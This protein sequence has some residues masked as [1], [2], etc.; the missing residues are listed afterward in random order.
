MR[1][2]Y[3]WTLTLIATFATVGGCGRKPVPGQ[4]PQ[5]PGEGPSTGSTSQ[6]TPRVV[7]PQPVIPEEKLV[8]KVNG[9][10][11]TQEEFDKVYQHVLADQDSPPTTD[12]KFK[13]RV[14]ILNDLIMARIITQK[15]LEAD[16]PVAATEI[17]L[18][19]DRVRENFHFNEREFLASLAAQGMTLEQFR[20]S[21]EKEIKTNKFTEMIMNRYAV[22]PTED[23]LRDWYEEHRAAYRIPE[24]VR[25]SHILVAL[26]R[27]ATEGQI[28]QAHQ[29][30]QQIRTEI[31]N[32][33]LDFGAAAEKYSD[34]IDSAT[35]GG[36]LG[37]MF[38]GM[39]VRSFEEAAFALRVGEVGPPVRTYR[40]WH[41]I[42][43][44]A[45]FPAKPMSFEEA[46]KTG[47]L[48]RDF[49]V[50][51]RSL[52]FKDWLAKQRT[53]TVVEILDPNIAVLPGYR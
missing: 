32:L 36:L 14:N 13:L 15:A 26:P 42:K 8:A 43:V 47:H 1:Y 38:P 33:G 22:N 40:G 10:G 34:D 46:L 53:Q 41:L 16:L 28:E 52:Y 37:D 23:D 45:R 9:E 5:P 17:E 6:R 12:E 24:R 35:A 39:M 21:V 31:L 4:L 30:A 44:N 2:R 11:I 29:R 51:R 25:V 3:F 27:D 50:N 48:Q 49:E 20:R 7:S 18:A 19:L